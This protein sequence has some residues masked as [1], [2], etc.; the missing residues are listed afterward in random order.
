MKIRKMA[1]I[2]FFLILFISSF[3]YNILAY[4][5][6]PIW[7]KNLENYAS[8]KYRISLTGDQ[9][10]VYVINRSLVTGLDA[11]DGSRKVEILPARYFDM[12]D[13]IKVHEGGKYIVSIIN[14]T[15]IS[16]YNTTNYK[17]FIFKANATVEN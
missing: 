1:I 10:I 15:Y 12:I 5:N 16:V 13:G 2:T 4:D 14:G 7:T 9:N 17:S 11:A 6:L 3:T 8:E